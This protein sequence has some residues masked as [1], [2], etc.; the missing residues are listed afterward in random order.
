MSIHALRRVTRLAARAVVALVLLA[1]P[2]SGQRPA[3][4]GR[5]A[6]RVV[7]QATGAPLSDVGIQ[8][9]G[10]TLG[11][12]SDADGRYAIPAIPAGTVTLH[13]RRIGFQPKT[14]TGI[15]L[16][17]GETFEQNVALGV[18]SVTLT[19]IEVTSAAERG[20]VR[21]ALEQQRDAA[22]I[23]SA[24]TAEQIS[25]SP[26]SDAAAAVQRV[27]GVTVQDGRFVHVRGLGERYTTTSLNGAR[28]PSP[29]PE[30]KAV[31]LDLFPAS[32]LRSV[33]TTKTF[34]PDQSGDFSGA[35]VDIRTRE[36][37]AERTVAYSVSLGMNARAAGRDVVAAPV[38]A[39]EWFG[40][41]DGRRE[42][43]DMVRRAGG[44]LDRAYTRSEINAMIGAFRNS[45]TPVE[46]AGLPNS[47]FGVTVGG[48]DPIFGR[49]VGY[50]G[51][52][53]YSLGQEIQAETYRAQ[54]DLGDATS[55]RPGNEFRGETGRTSV[56]WGGLFNLSTFLGDGTLLTLNNTFNRSAD[57]EASRDRGSDENIGRDVIFERSTLRYI[58]RSVRSHQLAAEHVL[59]A[60]HQVD[61]ALTNSAVTRL[62]PDRS[63]LV[64]ASFPDLETGA[65]RPFQLYSTAD[66]GARRTFGDLREN[67]W[68]AS[69]SY[70]VFLGEVDRR[71][72]V[73]VGALGRT[74]ERDA[75]VFQYAFT[76]SLPETDAQLPAE[77]IF[78]GRFTQDDMTVF[79]LQ[80]LGQAGSYRARDGL[81]AAY[82]MT[83]WALGERLRF[84]GGVRVEHSDVEVATLNFFG[85]EQVAS[86]VFTDWLPS[87]ALNLELGDRQQVRLSVSQTLARPEYR[88]L[89][90]ILHRDV[91]FEVAVQGNPALR[92]TLVRNADVRW[93]WY[94]QA[95]EVVSV[96][97]FAK[98]FQDP[99]ERV[100]T[101]TSGTMIHSFV[102]A[103]SASNYGVELEV[104]KGLGAFSD[105]L[106]PM[107]VFA[108]TTLMRSRIEIGDDPLAANTN[109][110][111]AMVGQAPYVVNA[112]MTW[113]SE[114][115]RLSATTLYNVVGERI[116]SAGERAGALVDTREQPRHALD[117]SLRA[118][119]LRAMSIKLDAKNLLDAPNRRTRGPIVRESYRSGRTFTVGVSWR[120]VGS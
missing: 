58:E 110:D 119:L 20:T 61:W 11:A 100:E 87:A 15:A 40:F 90:P 1:A 101:P 54:I 35:Q 9:V 22:G 91:L 74:T 56:L 38:A 96:A 37:P 36:F 112:G 79:H 17:A 50:I 80:P 67:A 48:N 16:A 23:V 10:T 99:I 55:S 117:L 85:Q 29:E 27:S 73:K 81:L 19:A 21:E 4:T 66:A 75:G 42:L 7:D 120:P 34:T 95:G 102:N 106:A 72:A 24:V 51:S 63:D 105:R 32:L 97:L 118:P 26:D 53:T 13:L 116:Y 52:F 84:V 68:E 60:R 76:G 104:R 2:L 88:E 64:Y 39:T 57:S 28:M 114:D 18:A 65:Q 89:S 107:S 77:Q 109:P 93:E 111:R 86:R 12:M 47:S 33:T 8:V 98:R 108:N 115:G 30:K 46:R 70:R 41:A 49:Q 6:G 113:A 25:R 82:V 3:S 62:E 94:P 71:N 45:W 44:F 59:G 83:D 31:P 103:A 5:I 92:R 78:D 43:P 14:V 69:A